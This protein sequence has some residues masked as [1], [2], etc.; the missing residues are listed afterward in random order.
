MLHIQK[1]TP[2]TSR[3]K[4][5]EPCRSREKMKNQGTQ[6]T[7]ARTS[8]PKHRRRT[9][10]CPLT[11]LQHARRLKQPCARRP[12]HVDTSTHVGKNTN[13]RCA[14]TLSRR[15][16][17]TRPLLR[18]RAEAPST[19]RASNNQLHTPCKYVL[20]AASYTSYNRIQD[21][22]RDPSSSC[23]QGTEQIHQQVSYVQQRLK[24]QTASRKLLLPLRR[25]NDPRNK[26]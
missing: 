21:R 25:T 9:G 6:I 1:P 23:R 12:R 5:S 19:A 10:V 14:R 2:R 11:A 17:F 3:G 16:A 18:P 7:T 22:Q 20:R 4:V 15:Q 13:D 8:R 26:P 24:A